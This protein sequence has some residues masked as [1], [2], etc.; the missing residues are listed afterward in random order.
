ML[1]KITI[2]TLLCF[3]MCGCIKEDT[4]DCG[5]LRL[6]FRYTHNDSGRDLLADN[7]GEIRVY[8]FDMATGLLAAIIHVGP[9][10]IAR[11][12]MDTNIA[13]GRYG[14]VAWGVGGDSLIDGGYSVDAVVGTTTLDDFRLML[15]YND[16][17]GGKGDT[18]AV[19]FKADFDNLFY[20]LAADV[21]VVGTQVQIV[22]FD[23]MKNTS[24]LK[25][26][27]NGLDHLSR[28]VEG[29]PLEV[30]CTGR[31]YLYNSLNGLDNQTPRMLYLPYDG[32]VEGDTQQVYI[33]QQR[34]SIA[35]SAVDPVM[36]Y[37]R[38]AERGYDLVKPLD[39]VAAIRQNPAYFDQDAI[40]REDLFVIELSILLDLRVSVEVNGWQIVILDP[41]IEW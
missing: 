29:L 34:L 7:V 2:F 35:Q 17:P 8:A 33:R 12:Y 11:G 30:F 14:F 31:N 9:D 38:H 36:L 28:A 15:D 16:A 22:D 40:D 23:L 39:L 5:R 21:S 37:V 25:V 19:P 10:D 6:Q 1:K 3:L 13:D 26:I 27:V 41:N 32:S 4:A 18:D 20:A 24:T